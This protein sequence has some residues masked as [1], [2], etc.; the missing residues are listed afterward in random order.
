MNTDTPNAS[1]SSKVRVRLAKEWLQLNPSE[2][3][4]TTARIFKLPFSTLSS[5]IT[6]G[7]TSRRKRQYGG[8]NIILNPMQSEQINAFIRSYLEHGQWPPLPSTPKTIHQVSL[9]GERL[10]DKIM[11]ILSSP[12]RREF[13]S[14]DKGLERVLFQAH[15]DKAQSEMIFKKIEL[16]HAK[17]FIVA[18]VFNQVVN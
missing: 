18:S 12:S 17:H 8:H 5:S 6:R 13:E 7:A 10:R 1:N 16:K 14:L 2:T 4:S 9:K 3:I 11:D 15:V